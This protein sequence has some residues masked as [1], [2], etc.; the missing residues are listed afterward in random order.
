MPRGRGR[1][2]SSPP[3]HAP[4]G[5]VGEELLRDPEAAAAAAGLRYV[6]DEEPGIVRKRWG[7]GFTYITPDGEHL[8][9][10]KERARIEALAIPP[11]Y[12]EVWICPREDGHLL[13]TGRD[14]EG[15]KQYVYHPAWRAVRE[16]AK[17]AHMISFGEG[18]P[19]LRAQV[20]RD[21]RGEGLE[22][23]RV[24][25]AVV[26]LLERT[27]IRVGNDEYARDN[28][29]YGLT[30]MRRKHVR[31]EGNRVTFDFTGKSG[32]EWRLD[33]EDADVA[34]V[35]RLCLETP[36]WEVFKYVDEDGARHD[37]TADEVNAYLHELGGDG[38][39]AKDFRTWAG[40][41]RAA[42]VL[43]ELDGSA[44]E[45]AEATEVAQ[46][47]AKEAGG[48]AKKRVVR[49]IERVAEELRNTPAVCRDNYIHPAVID[50]YHDGTLAKAFSGGGSRGRK[51][52]S[53][54]EAAVLAFL[55]EGLDS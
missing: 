8:R 14:A 51:G 27:L 24:L 5:A 23:R 30:T 22:R 18:L 53:K 37:V 43:V 34:E 46:A 2:G 55:K 47:A 15:R 26:R 45:V 54:E 49:A 29:T 35:V 38:V 9:D 50:G 13:A 41:V 31:V 44:A 11:A 33:L 4:N 6:S 25:A 10:E 1:G 48:D 21:L 16:R 52:L 12:T 28:H 3:V 7:K 42:C 40:T 20:E 36:G 32:Q 17:Y 19:R 39:S